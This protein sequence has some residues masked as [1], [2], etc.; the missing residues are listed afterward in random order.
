MDA[1]GLVA[2]QLDAAERDIDAAEG[3]LRSAL[4]DTDPSRDD[5]LARLRVPFSEQRKRLKKARDALELQNN[6]DGVAKAWRAISSARAGSIE[7]FLETLLF[8]SGMLLRRERLDGGTCALADVLQRELSSRIS[9]VAW[10]KASVPDVGDESTQRQSEL[11]RLRFPETSVWSLPIVAHEVGHVVVSRY[12]Q[13]VPGK[14]DDELVFQSRF[15]DPAERELVC[16]SFAS[17]A[18]GPAYASACLLIRFEPLEAAEWIE[19]HPPARERAQVILRTVRSLGSEP[20][21]SADAIEAAW[22]SALRSCKVHPLPRK[23]AATVD[24]I[25]D[26][27]LTE[28]QARLPDL[29][30][31]SWERAVTMAL[32]LEKANVPTVAEASF[33]DAL[34]AVWLVRRRNWGRN[35]TLSMSI[36]TACETLCR[37]WAA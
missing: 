19:G 23:R 14:T 30:Y 32:T 34:N 11:I 21:K 36:R 22:I 12:A 35:G 33:A 9:R 26:R 29:R 3:M 17:L 15:P 18:L 4:F 31:N 5:V 7:P 28:I 16:D 1:Y 2:A 13:Q 6:Q 20:A 27:G 8:L 25:A 37:R 24:S 10:P